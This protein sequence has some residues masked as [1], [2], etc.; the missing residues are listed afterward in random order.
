[1]IRRRGPFFGV[2]GPDYFEIAP[3]DLFR[4]TRPRKRHHQL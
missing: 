3:D 1:M 2:A 4:I